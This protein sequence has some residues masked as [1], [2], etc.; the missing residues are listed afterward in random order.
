MG[1]IIEKHLIDWVDRFRLK[2]G[3]FT[4]D[5]NVIVGLS[6]GMDSMLLAHITFKLYQSGKIKSLKFIHID[7][8]LRT[9][10]SLEAS[11]LEQW[12]LNHNWPLVIEK[13]SKNIPK[14][15]IE[16]WAR[17][18][19]KEIF[20]KHK[21]FLGDNTVV[22]L[23][24]HIDDSFEWHVRQLLNSSQGQHFF[25]I[26]VKNGIYRRPLHCLTRSHIRYWIKRLN[27]FY[28]KDSSN[29]DLKFERNFIR[30]KIKN[31]L[32]MKNNH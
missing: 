22:L 24:H 1:T 32:L 6:G 23:G 19:R 12:C 7:H 13:N 26:P 9:E 28:I 25:G 2:H 8:G 30:H 4:A 20:L 16:D 15:N 31:E 3:L 14:N 17:N 21:N 5:D 29:D 18:L 10:S 27:I 11:N